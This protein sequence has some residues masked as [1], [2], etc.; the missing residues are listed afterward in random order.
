[1]RVGWKKNILRMTPVTIRECDNRHELLPD[2]QE[3]SLSGS[4]E[5]LPSGSAS[6]P[7]EHSRFPSC[8]EPSTQL[9]YVTAAFPENMLLQSELAQV[10][11]YRKA[12]R[13]QFK[14][15]FILSIAH[16]D[17]YTGSCREK[18]FYLWLHLS[19]TGNIEINYGVGSGRGGSVGMQQSSSSFTLKTSS[20]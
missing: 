3:I 9:I 13:Y 18:W 6:R 5:D 8:L 14:S 4:G 15:T 7:R 10:E 11:A 17:K 16:A 2:P 12:E 19:K 20:I 1:M